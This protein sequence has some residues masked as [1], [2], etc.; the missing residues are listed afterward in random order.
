MLSFMLQTAESAA[1]PQPSSFAGLLAALAAP[2]SK[3]S[4]SWPDADLAEDV[5]TLSYE[6]ALQAHARFRQVASDEQGMPQAGSE[7]RAE[8][9]KPP[10]VA[11]PASDQPRVQPQAQVTPPVQADNRKG[12]SVTIRM[13]R[14]ECE[15]LRVRA[16]EAGM[17]ISAYLRSC[18]F[19][20]ETLR[21]QVKDAV[22]Q[23]RPIGPHRAEPS[24]RRWWQRWSQEDRRSA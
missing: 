6:R 1:A 22:A 5:V 13:T 23:M 9:P 15:Q 11:S 19:E 3:P 17:T 24:E 4:P 8:G 16:T 20:V 18:T 10:A 14:I 7:A 2:A 21:A 12:A